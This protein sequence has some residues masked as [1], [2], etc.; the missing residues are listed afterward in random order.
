MDADVSG[1]GGGG[2]AALGDPFD[3]N[4]SPG[5]TIGIPGVSLIPGPPTAVPEPAT[6]LLLALAMG[7]FTAVPALRRWRCD[8]RAGHSRP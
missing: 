1:F 4:G 3:V 6:L 7:L 5:S 2:V 8:G